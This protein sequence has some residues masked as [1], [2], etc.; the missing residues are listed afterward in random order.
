MYVCTVFRHPLDP[1]VLL[2]AVPGHAPGPHRGLFCT[3]GMPDA[4]FAVQAD[5]RSHGDTCNKYTLR[6]HTLEFRGDIYI[7]TA[8]GN[9]LIRHS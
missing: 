9:A 7:S 8:W 6:I 1:S 5:L 4:S 3:L 2:S